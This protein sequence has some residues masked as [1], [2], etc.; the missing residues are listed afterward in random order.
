MQQEHFPLNYNGLKPDFRR[1]ANEKS[2]SE[3]KKVKRKGSMQARKG[4][5]VEASVASA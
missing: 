3:Q 5:T 1:Q 2:K 4:L